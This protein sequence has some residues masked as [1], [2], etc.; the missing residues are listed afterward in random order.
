MTPPGG[1]PEVGPIVTVRLDA[2]L[3]AAVDAKA[4]R[5]GISRASLIRLLLAD[6]LQSETG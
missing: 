2:P 3:L 1:R 6:A 4:G 5:L